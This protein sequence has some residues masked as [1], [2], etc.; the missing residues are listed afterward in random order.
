MSS[1]KPNVIHLKDYR[2]PDFLIP[3]TGLDVE[4]LQTAA[5]V[6]TCLHLRRNP[7]A[8]S[9]KAPLVLN[10]ERLK[11]ITIRLNGETLK[12]SD[13]T[14]NE[15][16]L[17]IPTVPD[18][19][20]LE[21]EVEIRPQENKALEGLY[22]SSGIYC[23]QN[24]PEGFRKITYFLDRPDVM[25]KY[26]TRITADRKNYP[27][28]LSNGNPMDK[29][30]LD[31]GRHFVTWED[32]FPKPSYLFALVAGDLGE[33]QDTFKTRSGRTIA[34]K[35]FVDRG[36]EK[37]CGHAMRSLKNAMKWD[38]ERFGLECDLNTYMIVAVDAFNFG[39]MENKGLNIFNSQYVLAD[40]E[41]ATDQNYEAIENVIGHEY[42]HNWTGNRVTCRDWF[43]ITLKEGLT[44]FRDHEF[45][46]DMGSRA[47]NRIAAV[48]V[49]RDFQFV[50]DAG[51]NAH[52]IRPPSYIEINNFYTVTVYNKGS[53]VIGMIETL[54][55]RENFRKGMTKYFELFDGQAVTTEDFAHAMEQ[56]SGHDLTQFKNWY[57][58]AGTP[59]CRV[60]GNYDAAKKTYTL[61]V[62]QLPPRTVKEQKADPFYFPFKMGLLDAR[63]K[64]LPLEL[65]GD[66]KKETS[67]V[68][69]ISKKEHTFVFRNVPESPVPSL[70]RG[71]SAPVKLEYGYT[72][73]QLRFLLA[74]DS[75]A[76]N[77]YEAGQ[78]LATRALEDLIR[79]RQ[80]GR[81]LE[82]DA[83]FVAAFGSMLAD[84]SLDPALCAECMILP[85][86]TSLVERMEVCDFDAAFA[87]REHL[88]KS[89]AA[90]HEPQL[91]RIYGRYHGTGPYS[92]DSVSIG[93]R[94]FKNMALYY[95]AAL[96]TPDARKR[97]AEQFRH[98]GSMTDTMA[99]LDA[100]SQAGF[101][102]RDEALTAFA[103]KW[104]QNA[105]VMNKW[106]VVQAASKRPD[107]LEQV[108]K[109]E[110]DAAFDIKNPNKVRALFGVFSGNLVRFHDAAGEGYRFIAGK[111]LEIDTF[112]PS[113]ASK[114]AA[115]FKKFAKLD[116]GRK[117]LMGR[118]LERILA[119][120]GLSRDTYEIVSK[121]LESG[122]KN[123]AAAKA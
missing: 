59:V 56:A 100:M 91:I 71:F 103:L 72:P 58:Q 55:G 52:P 70:L 78:V 115:A 11:L 30:D 20:V 34:L 108:K 107:V 116:A 8:D 109:L 105:L 24:E 95:L 47:V 5:R 25:S 86:V 57:R 73:E 12:P 41:T 53:E 77:R 29:G 120:P 68:L 76:F 4:L 94:S 48:R 122:R 60:D 19:F 62:E 79:A 85:S 110:K 22:V 9:P 118:E 7:K 17:T 74:H 14:V 43:Q 123:A 93:K 33:V 50:E 113:A 117:E 31:G 121:T 40:P 84:E 3:Q 89:L 21:T 13:Y 96:G 66:S 6:K 119:A 99:A 75:D 26:T 106:F 104:R 46:A 36:N 65:E 42:F 32:P 92:P 63:G 16:H 61:K 88:L 98:A 28:L 83:G 81:K 111:I 54:I 90:A 101:P 2:P 18:V 49:L 1:D 15:T 82:A 67:K 69:V 102:E 44:F 23:T 112:N 27:V 38:E 35:I 37:K 80:E 10:G 45:S 87:A 97:V 51:P 114:L 39:A 64:D